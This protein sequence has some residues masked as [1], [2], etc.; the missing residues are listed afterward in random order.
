MKGKMLQESSEKK[1][2]ITPTRYTIVQSL[3]FF[4]FGNI[5]L[6]GVVLLH[7]SRFLFD[8]KKSK[9]YFTHLPHLLHVSIIC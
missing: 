4:F 7:I 1:A 8:E 5:S 2:Y 6:L 9:F 3:I